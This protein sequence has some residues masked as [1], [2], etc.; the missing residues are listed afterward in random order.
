MFNWCAYC[1]HFIGESAPY[2][3]LEISHGICKSCRKA[4]AIQQANPMERIKPIVD[5]H[6]ELRQK[7]AAARFEDLELIL[8]EAKHLGIT[9]LDL[10]IGLLQ[11][12]LF[13][14]GA[15]YALGKVTAVQEHNFV[16][17]VEHLLARI[18]R[19][20]TRGGAASSVPSPEVMLVAAPENYHVLGLKMTELILAQAGVS[21]V[22]VMPSLP[23][24]EIIDFALAYNPR[25]LGVSIRSLEDMEHLKVIHA[26]L[27][28]KLGSKAPRVCAG[29]FASRTLLDH[30]AGDMHAIDG[31]LHFRDALSFLRFLQAAPPPQSTSPE[32]PLPS[33]PKSTVTR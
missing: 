14:I 30:V 32:T 2:E 8:A 26:A 6:S 33:S 31:I 12:I 24:E 16:M 13:E 19:Q 25:I 20:S 1:Q 21:V 4:G 18:P 9:L 23:R 28:Q 5:F 29:G 15:Q 22:A 3:F 10:S 11:P 7:V 27:Q 17:L